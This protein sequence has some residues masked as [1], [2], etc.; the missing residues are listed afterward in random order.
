MTQRVN[1]VAYPSERFQHSHLQVVKNGRQ[2]EV[3]Q[4]PAKQY[5]RCHRLRS[6]EGKINA[7]TTI[8]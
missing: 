4:A 6:R 7:P 8:P 2:Q 5:E 3:K 1:E